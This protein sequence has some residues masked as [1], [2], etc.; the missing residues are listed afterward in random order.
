[1][2]AESGPIEAGCWSRKIRR[3]GTNCYPCFPKVMT[4][5]LDIALLDPTSDAAYSPVPV[6]VVTES[7]RPAIE[8]SSL[9][10]SLDEAAVESGQSVT[11]ARALAHESKLVHARLG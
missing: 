4:D 10:H 11:Q 3:A 2:R 7:S 5:D 9:L 1:M 6:P 8:V